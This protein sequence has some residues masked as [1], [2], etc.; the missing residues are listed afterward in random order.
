MREKECFLSCPLCM[1]MQ[2]GN[3][4]SF[5][6]QSRYVYLMLLPLFFVLYGSIKSARR[7]HGGKLLQIL[8]TY[9]IFVVIKGKEWCW[10]THATYCTHALRFV[11]IGEGALNAAKNIH[12]K[13]G[14]HK[15]AMEFIVSKNTSQIALSVTLATRLLLLL[16]RLLQQCY[17]MHVHMY[18]HECK[19]ELTYLSY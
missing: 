5:L 3:T 16:C 8:C 9:K 14:A 17:I 4:N 19:F 7:Q 10:N 12:R 11:A 18:T 6:H 1:S 15:M 13:L 2:P